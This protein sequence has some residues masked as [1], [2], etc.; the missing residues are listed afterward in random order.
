MF[1][2]KTVESLKSYV[3]IL[4]DPDTNLPFYV[5]KGFGNRVFNHVEDALKSSENSDKFDK[6][7]SIVSKGKQVEHYIVRHGMS[8]KMAVE[9]ESAFLDTFEFIP[10]LNDFKSGNVQG[11]I[12]TKDRGF[13]SVGEV[14]RRYNAEPLL[15]IPTNTVIININRTYV[16]GAGS[17]SIYLATKQ[18]WRMDDPR[19]GPLKFVLSEYQGLIVE[20]FEVDHWY[21]SQRGYNPGSK[22]FGKTYTGYGFEGKVAQESIREK[23]IDK[24]IAHY[25]SV[26]GRAQSIIY[27]L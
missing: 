16:R 12:A 5:G 3:Y 6:I 21:P 11:G 27:K 24:S 7:R 22:K 1:D 15:S 8:D 19:H 10:S 2:Q 26:R 17:E 20:V 4:V 25:K 13:M 23:Y 18:T 14:R 9:I